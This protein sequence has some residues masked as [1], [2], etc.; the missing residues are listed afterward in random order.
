MSLYICIESVFVA[1]IARLWWCW[2]DDE[3]TGRNR[4]LVAGHKASDNSEVDD[5]KSVTQEFLRSIHTSR[6]F[7]TN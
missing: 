5:E 6:L 3:Q 1:S 4:L 2:T 7:S